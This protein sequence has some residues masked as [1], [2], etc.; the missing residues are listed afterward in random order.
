MAIS[1]LKKI[2]KK[3]VVPKTEEKR[4]QSLK[5]TTVSS[6]STRNSLPISKK[7]S[8]KS[9]KEPTKPK[10]SLKREHSVSSINTMN[11]NNSDRPK[12]IKTNPTSSRNESIK[13]TVLPSSASASPPKSARTSPQSQIDSVINST[14]SSP[15]V[16]QLPSNETNHI[17]TPVDTFEDTYDEQIQ[18]SEKSDSRN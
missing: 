12:K 14:V 1:N 18:L 2:P 3:T 16:T 8:Q 17:E 15:S 11:S 6:S 5:P 4:S 9:T 10:T 13:S 7:P